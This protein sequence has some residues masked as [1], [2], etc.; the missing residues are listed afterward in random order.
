MVGAFEYAKLHAPFFTVTHVSWN[1]NIVRMHTQYVR[2]KQSIL[3]CNVIELLLRYPKYARVSSAPSTPHT[4]H[5]SY[6]EV[7]RAMSASET[8]PSTEGEDWSAS[9]CKTRAKKRPCEVTPVATY[10][11]T[12]ASYRRLLAL[13]DEFSVRTGYSVGSCEEVPQECDFTHFSDS[14]ANRAFRKRCRALVEEAQR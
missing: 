8:F 3:H 2:V 6:P 7:S 11:I 4:F 5:S 14:R 12:P 10:D 1:F 13:V 9:K